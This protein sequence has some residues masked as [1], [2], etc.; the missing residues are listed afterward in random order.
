MDSISHYDIAETIQSA[1]YEIARELGYWPAPM[2]TSQEVHKY[3]RHHRPDVYRYGGRNVRAQGVSTKTIFGKIIAGGRRNTNTHLGTATTTGGSLAY[4]DE[5]GDG[6]AETATVQLPAGGLTDYTQIKV[7]FTGTNAMQ[8]WE[9]RPPKSKNIS[10]DV[11]TAVFNSWLFINPELL[12]AYPTTADPAAIDISVVTNYVTSV[13]VY[14][15][16]ND[17]TQN[18]AE[19]VWEPTPNV[20]YCS[21]CSGAGCAA[22]SYTAQMG[23]LH[24][25]DPLRGFVVPTAATYDDTNAQWASN[26]LSLSRD[27]DFVKLWYYSGAL[28]Q[29]YLSGRWSWTLPRKWARTIA[30]LATARLERPFC[31]CGTATAL[32]THLRDDLAAISSSTQQARSYRIDPTLVLQ[33]PFG[34]K[35]GEVMAWQ[36]VLSERDRSLGGGAA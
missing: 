36:Q 17:P 25:R 19:I 20:G 8:E 35:R 28:S 3:P 6:F 5:D 23:C 13:D 4:T 29:E 33:N 26:S 31:S 16:Y 2:W 15:E 7:Y 22:C 21:I 34:T 32:A 18:S 24:I 12:A 30:Y 11:F 27:P 14:R 9:I 1:E 10:S